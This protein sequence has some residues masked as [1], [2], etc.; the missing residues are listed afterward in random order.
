M[1]VG[2]VISCVHLTVLEVVAVLPQASMAVN[3]LVCDAEQEVVDTD[4]S[5]NDMVTA[6]HA[7]VAVALPNDPAT[8]VGLHPSV[9]SA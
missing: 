7:S 1:N 9:T 5:V 4:P 3:V 2:G 6:P 8:S